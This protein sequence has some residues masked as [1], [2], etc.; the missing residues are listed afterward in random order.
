MS[1]ALQVMIAREKSSGVS[2]VA[3]F[4]AKCIIDVLENFWQPLFFLGFS[5]N[6]ILPMTDFMTFY[7]SLIFVSFAAR[8]IP[9][10]F[11]TT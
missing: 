3:F 1:Y 9:L 6:F 8:Y 7:T 11:A 2:I 5:Y 10:N 4:L